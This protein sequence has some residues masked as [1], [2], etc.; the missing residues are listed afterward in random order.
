MN[1]AR[2]IHN[3]KNIAVLYSFPRKGFM[4]KTWIF[5]ILPLA[6]S[7]VLC[8]IKQG[9]TLGRWLV[10]SSSNTIRNKWHTGQVSLGARNVHAALVLS[11]IRCLRLTWG[12]LIWFSLRTYLLYLWSPLWDNTW[13]LS[14]MTPNQQPSEKC[15]CFKEASSICSAS[16][17]SQVKHHI[18]QPV[19]STIPWIQRGKGRRVQAELPEGFVLGDKGQ[20]RCFAVL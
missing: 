15:A 6:F 8:P 11:R 16:P 13:Q 17:T 3:L 2:V 20:W 9:K 5:M 10:V 12:F 14:Q 4:V 18:Y 19:S 1:G 7:F